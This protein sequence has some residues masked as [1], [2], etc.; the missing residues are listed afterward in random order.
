MKTKLISRRHFLITAATAAATPLILRS[1]VLGAEAPGSH[2]RLAAIGC[3]GRATHNVLQSFVQRIPEARVVVA[4]DCFKTKREHFAAQVNAIHGMSVCEPV[5]DFRDVLARSDIDGVIISTQ[6]HWHVPL[7]YAAISAGKAVY[8]EKPLSI[9]MTWSQK[10]RTLA[11]KKKA[12]FQYGTQQRGDMP[13]FRR[14]CELVRNGYIGEVREVLAWCPGMEQQF[15]EAAVPPYGSTT[16]VAPPPDFDYDL[17]VGPAPLRPYTVDRCTKFGG[18]HIY[19]Y[20]LGFIAGWGAHPLDIAQWGLDLDHTGPTRVEGTGKL[21]P[22]G[23]LW[24]TAEMYDVT[25]EYANGVRVRLMSEHLAKSVVTQTQRVFHDHG[26]TFIGS[27]GWV[28]VDRM[29]LYASDRTLQAHEVGGN[30]IQL[31]RTESHARNFV[32]AMRDGI[33]TISPL[34]AAIRSDTLSHLGDIAIRTGRTIK[35]D[36]AAETIEG[37]AEASRML[38]RPARSEWDLLAG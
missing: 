18:F 6:D 36:P 23:S 24:N 20:A 33:P 14:A 27:K 15:G 26:T 8:V 16:P 25:Y 1:G 22:P 9:A 4:C 3:G 19:D 21:P 17:W 7:A 30:E 31:M 10:L 37:D 29:G 12:V 5:A 2:V 32:E 13:Q 11:T 35:W 38:H 28:S 34:E